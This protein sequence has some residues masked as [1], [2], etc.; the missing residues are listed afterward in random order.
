VIQVREQRAC[1]R[2][3]SQSGTIATRCRPARS[4]EEIAMK[5]WIGL[6]LVAGALVVAAPALMATTTAAPAQTIMERADAAKASEFTAQR[7]HRRYYR[8]GYRPDYRPYYY[9]RPYYY[10]PYPYSSPAPFTFGFGFG[11]FWW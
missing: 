2:F 10:R 11:P 4:F 3:N 5:G 1:C 6:A 7:H 9:A 8:D